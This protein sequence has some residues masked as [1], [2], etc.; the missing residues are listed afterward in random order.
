MGMIGNLL[1]LSNDELNEYL[2]DSLL[3]ENSVYNDDDP[4]YENPN[5]S[6]IGKAWEGILFLLTGHNS[7]HIDNHPLAKVLFSGQLIDKDQ[8]MG[9]GPAH[10]LM[11]AQ[12]AELYDQLSAITAEELKNR[13]NPKRMNELKI[14]PGDWGQEKE[15]IDFLLEHFEQLKNTFLKATKNGEGIITFTN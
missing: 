4:A 3:L 8:D 10:Y 2:K 15:D 1:R 6:D 13:Y 7:E 12:V 5:L 14:Y 9:Y 11:P